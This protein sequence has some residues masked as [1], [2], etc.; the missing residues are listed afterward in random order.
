MLTAFAAK[1][2]AACKES[3]LGTS[4]M[5]ELERFVEVLEI[6]KPIGDFPIHQIFELA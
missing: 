6:Y 5:P 1:I 2:M 3:A 4:L